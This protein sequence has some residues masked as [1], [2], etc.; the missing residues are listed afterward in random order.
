MYA[1]P[2]TIFRRFSSHENARQYWTLKKRQDTVANVIDTLTDA[3]APV[4]DEVVGELAYLMFLSNR[5][6]GKAAMARTAYDSID[7]R[8]I[9]ANAPIVGYYPHAWGTDLSHISAAIEIRIDNRGDHA[10]DCA[11]LDVEQNA[12]SVQTAH[13]WVSA[14]W[15]A[16]P[17]GMHTGNGFIRKPIIYIS[18]SRVEELRTALAGQDYELWVA[19]WGVGPT[20][21]PGALAHQYTDHG[22]NGENYDMSVV[23]DD[24]WGLEPVPV[25]PPAPPVT[26]VPPAPPETHTGVVVWSPNADAPLSRVVHTSDGGQTWH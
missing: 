23:F 12:A 16:H 8:N 9:P 3:H 15:A 19:W 21:I 4:P 5:V 7:P 24:T 10:D 11:M 1:T 6:R 18:E 13:V 20:E 17:H 25:T 26:P 14:W 22:P 2:R